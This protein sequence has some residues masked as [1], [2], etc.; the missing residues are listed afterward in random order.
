MKITTA[1]EN[2]LASAFARK[3]LLSIY[4]L[5]LITAVF[6]LVHPWKLDIHNDVPFYYSSQ[7]YSA[8]PTEDPDLAD[9][10]IGHFYDPVWANEWA[11]FAKPLFVTWLQ[12][13]DLTRLGTMPFGETE[14]P[15][16]TGYFFA[17]L[18]THWL[19][20]LA[21]AFLGEKFAGMRAGILAAT[22]TGC[23]PWAIGY[24]HFPLYNQFSIVVYLFAIVL[25]LKRSSLAS[26]ASGI[27]AAL[28]VLSSS[29][30]SVY[31][32]GLGVMVLAAQMPNW[33]KAIRQGFLLV[34]GFVT[35]FLFLELMLV[36]GVVNNILGPGKYESPMNFIPKYYAMS[37]EGWYHL[38][39]RRRTEQQVLDQLE[40]SVDNPFAKARAR[41]FLSEIPSK[42]PKYP[43]FFFSILLLQSKAML[44]AIAALIFMILYKGMS[45]KSLRFL[46]TPK[47]KPGAL[48]FVPAL[49]ATLIIDWAPNVQYARSYFPAYPLF[50][51][52]FIILWKYISHGKRTYM[53]LGTILLVILTAEL[54]YGLNAQYQAYHSVRKNLEKIIHTGRP[55]IFFL[56]DPHLQDLI[57]LIDQPPGNVSF[58]SGNEDVISQA[59]TQGEVFVMTGPEI[60]TALRAFRGIKFRPFDG[61]G[62]FYRGR[63]VQV[64]LH[65]AEKIPFFGIWPLLVLEDEFDTMN[66]L[67]KQKFDE[68][69]YRSGAG[70]VRLW[71]ISAEPIDQFDDLMPLVRA[72]RTSSYLQGHPDINLLDDQYGT[73]WLLLQ[74]GLH[75]PFVDIAFSQ[76]VHVKTLEL[77]AP[78]LSHY[79]DEVEL[80]PLHR[81]PIKVRLMGGN[82][83]ENYVPIADVSCNFPGRGMWIELEIPTHNQFFSCYRLVILENNGSKM[84]VS[85]QSL[86]F[87]GSVKS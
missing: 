34:L 10:L 37:N 25:A 63:G 85:L 67:N 72:I 53:M 71:R 32:F 50:I 70:A 78:D 1:K 24:M 64:R 23:C 77:Q 82:D 20:T 26:F 13:W 17:I 83:G 8:Q 69:S 56:Y 33:I 44:L 27:V 29:S 87:R 52:S 15:N 19:M 28:A 58:A 65:E 39:N 18:M 38:N 22:L 12:L 76:P 74:D 46:Q 42:V 54:A 4:C 81:V 30:M 75:A 59:L 14:W 35:V 86:R 84:F 49:T 41:N 3:M 47:I 57:N 16:R 48:L 73:D 80:N 40:K 2:I 61:P 36:C 62:I 21:V 68:N 31:V 45:E 51:L 66:F 9:Q 79:A 60:E 7:T 11:A 55:L 43:F 5:V 6:L